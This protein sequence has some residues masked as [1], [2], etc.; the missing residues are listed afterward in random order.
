M[1]RYLN[2]TAPIQVQTNVKMLLCQILVWPLP[3]LAVMPPSLAMV[4]QPDWIS[5]LAMVLQPDWI[6]SLAMVLLVEAKARHPSSCRE[7]YTAAPTENIEGTQH[8]GTTSMD[9]VYKAFKQD[10]P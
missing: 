1:T 2:Y 7:E 10:L 9:I 4:L 3:N 6:G 8:G 5:S